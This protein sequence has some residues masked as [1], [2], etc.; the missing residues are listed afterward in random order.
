[1]EM[2]RTSGSMFYLGGVEVGAMPCCF[3][4]LLGKLKD[5]HDQIIVKDICQEMADLS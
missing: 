1:M 3:H 2:G 5:N 4:R